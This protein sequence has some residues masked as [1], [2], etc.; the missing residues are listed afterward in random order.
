[1]VSE[2]GFIGGKNMVKCNGCG[3]EIK[4]EPVKRIINKKEFIFCC[5]HCADHY[6]KK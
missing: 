3:I 2:V 5:S 4:K 6:E 1:M